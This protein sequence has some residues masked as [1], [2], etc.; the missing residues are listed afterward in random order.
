MPCF[1]ADL[2]REI[3]LAVEFDFMTIT[4]YGQASKPAVR[5]TL[6]LDSDI[7][8]R[9]IVLIEDIVDNGMIL[10]YLSGYLESN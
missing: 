7:S 3:T 9:D 4:G 8:G 5:I 1:M 6:D 2:I 10:N